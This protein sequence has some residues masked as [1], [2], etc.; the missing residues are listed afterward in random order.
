MTVAEWEQLRRWRA[1]A[2]SKQIEIAKENDN[3]ETEQRNLIPSWMH[4]SWDNRPDS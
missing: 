2:R 4:S 1:L 3:E